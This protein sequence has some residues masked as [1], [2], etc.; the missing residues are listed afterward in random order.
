MAKHIQIILVCAAKM[1]CLREGRVA[2]GSGPE[3]LSARIKSDYEL[4][5]KVIRIASVKPE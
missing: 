5:A 4:W 1:A 2:S 3:E